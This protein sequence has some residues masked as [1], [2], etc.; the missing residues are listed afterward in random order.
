[1]IEQIANLPLEIFTEKES[2]F[3]IRVSKVDFE[4]LLPKKIKITAGIKYV[5]SDF[6][7]IN[8]VNIDGEIQEKYSNQK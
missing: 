1:M 4:S 3:G 6:T 2:P 7:N 8:S 5:K